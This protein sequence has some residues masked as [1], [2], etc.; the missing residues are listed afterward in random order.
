MEEEQPRDRRVMATSWWMVKQDTEDEW[1]RGQIRH[2]HA[3]EPLTPYLVG[4]SRGGSVHHFCS[5]NGSQARSRGPMVSVSVGVW[6]RLRVRVR[7]RV[8][9]PC[10][11]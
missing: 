4:E 11:E 7:V 1:S 6:V 5:R 10:S 3:S 9:A 8:Y 2:M